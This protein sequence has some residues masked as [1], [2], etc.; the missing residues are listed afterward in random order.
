MEYSYPAP[1][2]PL[3]KEIVMVPSA[4]P[5]HVISVDSI[6]PIYTP[7]PGSVIVSVDPD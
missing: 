4:S 2:P 1:L 6:F 5:K 3:T 7:D